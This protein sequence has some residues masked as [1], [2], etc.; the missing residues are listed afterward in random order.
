MESSSTLCGGYSTD[1]RPSRPFFRPASP[2]SDDRRIARAAAGASARPAS[3]ITYSAAAR[4][5]C[6]TA[7]A[8]PSSTVTLSSQPMQPV[9]HALAIDQLTPGHQVLA[10][11]HE[12][13]FDHDA[14]DAHVTG[15][16]LLADVAQ[17]GYLVLGQQY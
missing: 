10:P 6:R 11:R 3:G 13:A 12:M 5:R 2:A 8:S 17:H 4:R 7:S 16:H 15:R 9:G 1:V 14:E